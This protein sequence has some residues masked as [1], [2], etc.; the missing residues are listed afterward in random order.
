M[1]RN[2]L[3]YAIP[4]VPFFASLADLFH[5]MNPQ[6]SLNDDVNNKEE[7]FVFTDSKER[8]GQIVDLYLQRRVKIINTPSRDDSKNLESSV[9]EKLKSQIIDSCHNRMQKIAK[10]AEAF[11]LKKVD[12]GFRL[13]NVFREIDSDYISIGTRFSCLSPPVIFCKPSACNVPIDSDHGNRQVFELTPAEEFTLVHEIVH[14]AKSHALISLIC[15]I[16]FSCFSTAIW[17][18][19]AKHSLLALKG[20]VSVGLIIP[21]VLKILSASFVYQ[22]F[23]NALNRCQEKEAD[24]EAMAYLQSNEG[25]IAL[26][27]PL[28]KEGGV[29]V[30]LSHPPLKE[31]LAYCRA[32]NLPRYS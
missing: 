24:C 27:E 12:F 28:E 7:N 13:P 11:G 14:I 9:I 10:I 32:M 19:V 21:E 15:S 16:A 17:L 18:T 22:L 1:G 23:T 8:T 6:I 26:F 25:A 20:K 2:A 31:R 30:D 5:Q 3:D 4:F 29:V